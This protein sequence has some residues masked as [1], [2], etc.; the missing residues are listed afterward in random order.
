MAVSRNLSQYS[1]TLIVAF[2]WYRD[3]LNFVAFR[4]S[5]NP[6]KRNGETEKVSR[7]EKCEMNHFVVN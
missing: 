7:V 1:L 6:T 4:A 3:T 5:T 2:V